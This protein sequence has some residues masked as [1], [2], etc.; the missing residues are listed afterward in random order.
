MAAKRPPAGDFVYKEN[1]PETDVNQDSSPQEAQEAQS[2][3]PEDQLTEDDLKELDDKPIPYARFKEV[4]EKGK[5]LAR[6]LEDTKTSYEQQMKMLANQYEAKLAAQANVKVDD[7][8]ED[9][10]DETTKT[11]RTLQS[12]IQNL[13]GEIS[14]LKTTQKKQT[15]KAQIESLKTKYPEA[16]PLAVQGWNVV[17]PEASLEELMAKSHEDN[18]KR[19][20]TKLTEIINR[21]KEK[22]KN[23][24]P[25]GRPRIQL[26]ED[27]KPKTFRDATTLAKRFFPE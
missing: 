4:N 11:I 12:T 16:D 22:S 18:S 10:E 27:E 21:K 14:G 7:P 9:Y 19:V 20:K 6:Q 3:S 2:A 25:T 5:A 24:V 15:V 17:L 8:Y 23:P 13:Q 1:E 26:K